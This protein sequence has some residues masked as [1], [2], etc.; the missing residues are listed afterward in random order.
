M[1]AV[2]CGCKYGFGKK[3]DGYKIGMFPTEIRGLVDVLKKHGPYKNSLEIGIASGGTCRYIREN[4]EIKR[5]V[6]V[7]NGKREVY[8]EF[9]N[10]IKDLKGQF[11]ELIGDSKSKEINQIIDDNGPYDLI[12]IDGE[13]TREA[14]EHDFSHAGS[15]SV[16]WMHD[17]T[18]VKELREFWREMSKKHLVLMHPTGVFGIGV[19]WLS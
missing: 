2:K 14:V 11:I 7:D 16:V 13:H 9:K 18:M 4:V 17:I 8:K 15:G 12:G 3:E 6:T 5:T 10:N 19:L 1:D